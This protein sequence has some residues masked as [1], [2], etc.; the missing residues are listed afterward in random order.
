[1]STSIKDAI[2]QRQVLHPDV[3]SFYESIL[4]RKEKLICLSRMGRENN[5]NNI[6]QYVSS[7]ICISYFSY[8]YFLLRFSYT[9]LKTCKYILILSILYCLINIIFVVLAINAKTIY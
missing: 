7:S 6:H 3:E 2:A 5:N 8:Y 9:L 1:M 4:W